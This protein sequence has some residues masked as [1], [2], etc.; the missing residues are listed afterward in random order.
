MAG[1]TAARSIRAR[2]G[3][4]PPSPYA[5]SVSPDPPERR[6]LPF[7]RQASIWVAAGRWSTA[8]LEFGLAVVLFF[9]GGQALDGYW[10]TTPWMAAV[11]ALVGVAVGMWLLLRPLLRSGAETATK[12]A[13]GGPPRPPEDR[14]AG[15]RPE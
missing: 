15:G 1:R 14:E 2:G 4:D 10:G 8:G 9:L 5:T 13:A 11:G 6:E 3:G 12:G 7:D